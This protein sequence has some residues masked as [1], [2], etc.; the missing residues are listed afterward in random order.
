MNCGSFLHTGCYA[1][2]PDSAPYLDENTMKCVS[3][4]ECS[5]FYND[6]IPAGEVIEDNCGRTWY[7][8]Y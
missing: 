8:L 3:L 5:C 4:S 6:I 1:K 2:C 7:I